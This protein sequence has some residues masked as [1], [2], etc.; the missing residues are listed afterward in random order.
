MLIHNLN[1]IYVNKNIHLLKFIKNMLR[2]VKSNNSKYKYK[3]ENILKK[4]LINNNYKNDCRLSS[5][6]Q[7]PLKK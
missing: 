4:L 6:G 3:K 2:N 5:V 7:S 1:V